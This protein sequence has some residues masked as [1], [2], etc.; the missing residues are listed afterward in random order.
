MESSKYS[1]N[2]QIYSCTE[3]RIILYTTTGC[4][5]CN[6][7]K[8]WLNDR[9]N[10]FEEKD[11]DDVD[12]MAELVMKN[13]VILSSPVLEVGETI[14]RQNEIFDEDG[15]INHKLLNVLEGK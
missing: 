4:S 8:E 3:N 7:L 11:L 1:T 14:Y 12:T 6:T 13:E 15:R 2:S 9:Q 5:R 10:Y